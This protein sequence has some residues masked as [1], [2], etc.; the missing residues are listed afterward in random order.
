MRTALLAVA[1]IL[2]RPGQ[3]WTQD[4]FDVRQVRDVVVVGNV[5]FAYQEKDFE[6]EPPDDYSLADV[7]TPQEA[8]YEAE[9]QFDD[10][11][12]ELILWTL[13]FEH[14]FEPDCLAVQ[15]GQFGAGFW[16]WSISG[17]IH[18]EIGGIGGMPWPFQIWLRGDGVP[19]KPTIYLYDVGHFGGDVYVR[20][21]LNM[22]SIALHPGAKE[23]SGD[24]IRARA[25]DELT[26]FMAEHA[27]DELPETPDPDGRKPEWKYHSQELIEDTLESRGHWL[28]E[29]RVW[30]VNFIDGA[31][32][33]E[34]YTANDLPRFHI[35]LTEDGRVGTLDLGPDLSPAGSGF[36][37]G[38]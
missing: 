17:S 25:V 24:E 32:V 15:G 11:A 37:P 2:A 31:L 30:S 16:F 14:R 12:S 28:D 4:E 6:G 21:Y 33:D 7:I 19:I 18:P 29:Q 1:F 3:A 9:S 20:S 5:L 27:R 38:D 10:L 34:E 8:A 35:W 36:P 23:L 26:K 13:G 22:D